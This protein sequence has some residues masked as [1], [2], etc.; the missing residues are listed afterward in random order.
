MKTIRVL[1]V[2]DL[3]EV[4]QGLVSVLELA[5]RRVQPAIEVIGAAENG[6]EALR[7]AR[8][9]HPDVIL[10]DLEMPVLDGYEATRRI[11][12]D[13]P[14]TRVIILS[15]HAGAD[16]MQRAREAGA[17]EYLVKGASYQSLLS[18][19]LR[20]ADGGAGNLLANLELP[21]R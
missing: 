12:A 6:E 16:A 20:L 14:A 8:T 5:A 21:R 18:A 19:I 1:V 3:P 2:D 11:K 9:L 4:R 17:D 10:M 7:Q 15:I 13:H